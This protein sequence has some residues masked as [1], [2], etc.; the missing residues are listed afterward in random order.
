MTGTKGV[1][2][3]EMK[4]FGQF[5]VAFFVSSHGFGHAARACAVGEALVAA[6]SDTRFGFYSEVPAWFFKDSLGADCLHRPCRTDVGLVQDTPFRHDLKKTL[7]ALSDFFPF[8]EKTVTT[9]AAELSDAGCRLVVCDVSALGIAVARASGI[10]SVLLENFTWDWVYEDFVNREPGF[11]SF[12]KELRTI[13]EQADLHLQTE[14]ICLPKPDLPA[15]PPIYRA[16]RASRMETRNQLGVPADVK[17]GLLTTGGIRGELTCLDR[18]EGISKTWFVAPGGC[19]DG[20]ER[21]GNVVLLSHRSGFHHPDLAAASDFLVGKAGYG[22]IAE[23]R[24]AGSSFAYVLRE[25]FRESIPLRE[26]LQREGMGF[27]ITEAEFH[28]A[29]WMSRFDE[30]LDASDRLKPKSNGA[31]A[32]AL[33]LQEWLE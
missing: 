24:A 9:L 22:T 32:A 14:P 8:D 20:V 2:K 26:Y 29:S 18:L 3:G 17:L 10:P 31:M 6:R 11:A 7:N 16:H 1:G 30:L 4:V 5:E 28:S 13:Y 33:A 12:T 25:D 15:L 27:E 23:A 19:E 21:R